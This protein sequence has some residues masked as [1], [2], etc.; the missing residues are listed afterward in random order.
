MIHVLLVESG[1]PVMYHVSAY[2]LCGS[3][4]R[5]TLWYNDDTTLNGAERSVVGI[6]IVFVVLRRRI[7][8]ETQGFSAK[9]SASSQS[10]IGL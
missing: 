8:E 3:S 2:I 5:A 7:L 9:D 10:F 6:G 1:F 4:E